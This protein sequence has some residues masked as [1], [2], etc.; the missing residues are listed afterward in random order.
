M[1]T[2]A[3]ESIILKQTNTDSTLLI[4]LAHPDDESFGSPPVGT[5]LHYAQAGVAV[6]YVCATRGEAGSVDAEHLAGFASVGDLRSHELR[7][8]AQVLGLVSLHFLNYRDSG[9]ENS[10]ENQRPDCLVQ[11]PL[12]AVAEKITA[13]I[14]QLKPQVVL[15][16]DPSGGYFHPDHIHTHK[17]TTL[18]F[19]KS[20]D[21][22]EFPQQLESGLT[23]YQPQKLYYTAFPRGF[24]RLVVKLLPLFG[25]DPTAMGRNKDINLKRIADLEQQITTKL[26][27]S[28]YFATSRQAAACHASQVAGVP[29]VPKFIL[30]WLM[31][32]EA[33][34]RV[35]PSFRPGEAIE[36]DLF[37]GIKSG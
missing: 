14:R 36:R 15:T 6:H 28:P 27:V 7:C 25:K 31:R 19:H 16:F 13:L 22:A 2:N 35:F 10:P 23:P 24:F 34:S 29:K 30:K 32:Y 9:M 20:G 26:R 17:A 33:Y 11:A 3:I 4:V 1:T 5:I 37:V 12:E 8:A 18:A 21:S